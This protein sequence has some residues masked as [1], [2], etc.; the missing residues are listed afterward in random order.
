VRRAIEGG[1][2]EELA[3]VLDAIQASGALD[4]A[5]SQ[6]H[7][8]AGAAC[9]ALAALPQSKARDYLLELADFAVTRTF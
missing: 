4:Y 9:R 6:A 5:R 8:E 2:I 1:R 3:S 7:A